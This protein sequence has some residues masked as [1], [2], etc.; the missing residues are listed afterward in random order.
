MFYLNNVICT[1]QKQKDLIIIITKSNHCATKIYNT[2][3]LWSPYFM[4]LCFFFSISFSKLRLSACHFTGWCP[5]LIDSMV[6]RSVMSDS[7][8]PRGLQPTR[9][10]CLWDSPG[11]NTGVGCHFLLQGIFPTQGQTQVSHIAGR[12]F[13]L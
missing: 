8:P 3:M 4:F 10:L 1:T 13:N 2:F 12:C 7:L 11:K 9:L 6:S 5:E